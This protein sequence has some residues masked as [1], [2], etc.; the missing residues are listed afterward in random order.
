M[1][2]MRPPT[3][4]PLNWSKVFLEFVSF[5]LKKKKTKNKDFYMS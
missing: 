3:H 5:L 1:V 4:L 2:F